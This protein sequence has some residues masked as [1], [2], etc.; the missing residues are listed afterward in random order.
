[1]RPLLAAT[2]S[3]LTALTA[4]AG[5]TAP[6]PAP[7]KQLVPVEPAP[8]SSLWE[9]NI[10]PYGW[11][12]S[13]DA[14][15]AV[16]GYTA[17]KHVGIEDILD[18][19]DMVWMT[20][21]EARRGRWGGWI[22]GV[23]LNMTSDA[24]SPGPLLKS[25]GVGSATLMLEGALYYR[26]LEGPDG[27]LDLYGGARYNRTETELNFYPSDSGIQEVAENLSER[28][29]DAVDAEIRDRTQAALGKAKAAAA[30]RAQSAV[31]SALDAN[32]PTDDR[33]PLGGLRRLVQADRNIQSSIVRSR[34]LRRAIDEVATARIESRAAELDHA[35]AVAESAEAQVQQAKATARHRAQ[36]AVATAEK[37]LASAIE[38]TIRDSIPDQLSQTADWID[39]FVGLRGKYNLTDRLY[40]IAKAD[41]GGFGVGSDLT[42]QVYGAMG[43]RINN[44]WSTELGYRYMD[45]DYGADNGFKYDVSMGG[46]ML[47]ATLHF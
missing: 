19:L 32:R 12:A 6:A 34:V 5:T 40:V 42:W 27:F 44:R 18:N 4:S 15:L 2:A 28:V 20:N 37:R 26:I 38:R 3:L 16:Q 17:S 30:S 35:Q 33:T 9:I 36:Q 25:L 14:G 29:V 46:P 22:D 11:M 13:I 41:V 21:I 43:W 1:M 24:E 8:E 31:R 45:I 47:S 7:A 23:Y 39:P 10:T